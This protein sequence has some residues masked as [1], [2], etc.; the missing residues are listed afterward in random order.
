MTIE[1]LTCTA[2]SN[3]ARAMGTQFLFAKDS[4]IVLSDDPGLK[5]IFGCPA[6]RVKYACRPWNQAEIEFRNKQNDGK[7]ESWEKNIW[8]WYEV[9]WTKVK[10]NKIPGTNLIEKSCQSCNSL[11]DASIYYLAVD[12]EKNQVVSYTSTTYWVSDKDDIPNWR[13]RLFQKYPDMEITA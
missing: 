1:L 3:P 7:L 11:S 9:D 10:G 2:F 4:N 5:T 13:K 8:A 6:Q 12:P